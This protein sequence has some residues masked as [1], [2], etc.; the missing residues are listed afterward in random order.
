M[1]A[2]L[3][4]ANRLRVAKLT[5]CHHQMQPPRSLPSGCRSRYGSAA[6][7][8]R[9]FGCQSQTLELTTFPAVAKDSVTVPNH[10]AGI[11]K[12]LQNGLTGGRRIAHSVDVNNNDA[13]A[14]RRYG[15]L[16]ARIVLL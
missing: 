5:L 11:G 12:Q 13:A 7:C 10:A 4:P 8:R 1:Q 2:I 6:A 9:P 16:H 14:P 3:E 15:L